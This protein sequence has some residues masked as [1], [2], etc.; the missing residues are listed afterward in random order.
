[1]RIGVLSDTHIRAG[2]SLPS[3]VFNE[4][5]DV[6]MIFHAGDILIPQV[7][8]DLACIAPVK[9][10]RGNC[11]GWEL[12]DLPSELLSVLEGWRIGLVHGCAG[13]GYDTP[14]RAFNT[15]KDK[16]VNIIIFGHSH[17]P[18]MNWLNGVLLFNPGSPTDKRR[19]ADYSLGII[20]LVKDKV[21]AHHIFFK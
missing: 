9:A 6:E 1:M 21:E 17:V 13:V 20:N 2:K 11:D 15:F 8:E 18:Y 14:E 16:G 19:Q 7:L 3:W 10:V 4:L 12:A 5:A